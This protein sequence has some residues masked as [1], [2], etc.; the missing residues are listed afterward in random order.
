M[1]EHADCS[2]NYY[3][4]DKASISDDCFFQYKDSI[5]LGFDSR[6]WGIPMNQSIWWEHQDLTNDLLGKRWNGDGDFIYQ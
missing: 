4:F 3:M 5:L 6:I 2:E 1:I